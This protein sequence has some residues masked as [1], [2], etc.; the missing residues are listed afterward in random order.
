LEKENQRL[1]AALADIRR[2]RFSFSCPKFFAQK[3]YF[4]AYLLVF[5]VTRGCFSSCYR[6]VFV[7]GLGGQPRS[8]ERIVEDQSRWSS[9]QSSLA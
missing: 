2:K 9:R 4:I 5:G 8:R 1:S 3:N 6:Q 7:E